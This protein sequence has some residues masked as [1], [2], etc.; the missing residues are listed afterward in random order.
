MGVIGDIVSKRS[1]LRLGARMTPELEV[2]NFA[3]TADRVRHPPLAV[4]PDGLFAAIGQRAIVLDEAFQRF[5]SKIEPIKG[6]VTALERSHH[7][8]G[9]RVVIETAKGGEAAIERALAGMT[10]GRVSEVMSK[11][12]RLRQILIEAKGARQR[13]GDLRDLERVGQPRAEMIALVENENLGLVT[14]PAEGAGMDDPIAIAAEIVAGRARR[15]RMQPAAAAAGNGG[16]RG[17]H[18]CRFDYHPCVLAHD[19]PQCK[20]GS[21]TRSGARSSG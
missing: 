3:I 13:A 19:G 5:P 17:A 18:D 8:Q 20:R 10:E 14:E 1:D 4:A 11:R 15:L 9:L 21:V 6:R 12:Q 7:P 16:I 2:L